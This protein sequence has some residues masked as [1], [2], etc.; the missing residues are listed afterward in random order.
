MPTTDA[1]QTPEPVT[2]FAAHEPVKRLKFGKG[3]EFQLGLRH[4]VDA[5]F[6]TTGRSRRDC[7]QMYVKTFVVL[8]IFAASYCLLVFAAQTWWQ[9]LPLA[10]VLGLS[11]SQIGFNIQHDGGHHAYSDRAWINQLMAMTL[12]LIGGSSYIW[13]WKH[14]VIHHT[15]VNV[16]GHDSDID[17]GGLGRLSPHQKRYA[18]HRYQHYYLWP[19]Y[20]LMAI[21]W[22]VFDDFHDVIVGHIGGVKF[23]RPKG[24]NLVGFLVGKAVFFTFALLI[25]LLYHP[26]WQVLLFYAITVIVLGMVISVVFQLAHAVE[27]AKFP[28]PGVE[29]GR[30]DKPWAEHQAETTVD[31]ARQSRIV[32]WLLGGLNFQIEHHLY[33][34]ICH[35]NY[36]AMSKV[37]EESCRQHGITYQEHKSFWAGVGSHFRWLREMGA[38]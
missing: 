37:V 34:D 16:T 38:A 31:F 26:L 29:S 33:P 11:A 17:M 25:P 4:R 30:M 9:A 13:H 21:K 1:S 35:V 23:P 10:I 8:S 6:E 32:T 12:D 24:W 20:G 22:H 18:F 7:L 5:F 15:Y 36:P 3:N 19:L 2:K 27:E 28:M 14:V